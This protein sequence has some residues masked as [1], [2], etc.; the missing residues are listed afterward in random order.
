[1]TNDT[2]SLQSEQS[3]NKIDFDAKVNQAQIDKLIK[4]NKPR[5][6]KRY[7]TLI[8]ALILLP[9]LG[10]GGFR[11]YDYF[12]THES[13]DDAYVQAHSDPI[14]SRLSGTVW[15]VLVDDNQKVKA[16]DI[17]VKLDPKDYEVKV[18]QAQSKV[19]SA[20]W[21][22]KASMRN[23]PVSQTQAIGENTAA[24]GNYDKS[25]FAI[26]SALTMLA[27]DEIQIKANESRLVKAR[28]KVEK[29][30]ADYERYIPLQKR[31][32]ITDQLLDEAKDAYLEAKA[33]EETQIQAIS[34][35]KMHYQQ[36]RHNLEEARAESV[37]FHGQ[38]TKAKATDMQT[39][40]IKRQSQAYKAQ[41]EEA[42][43]NLAEA[44]LNLSYTD[45][46]A[47][48][49][50]I[51]GRKTVETGQRVQMGEALMAVVESPPWIVANFKEI[52]LE[53]MRPNQLVEITV[54][55]FKHHKFYGYIDSIAPNSGSQFA[56]LPPDNATGNFTKIVQRVP[57]K[58]RFTPD[59]IRG[60]EDKVVPGL[61]CVVTVDL[62]KNYSNSI[63]Q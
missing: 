38:L 41:Y 57:V 5:M 25:K 55:A 12:M 30:L 48:A 10:F 4:A 15:Q 62:K 29:T 3:S 50:G 19:E 36:S 1:M 59:S 8:I 51:I 11:L 24:T 61:S 32:V 52:Q 21:Q 39:E 54:D 9:I 16:G 43:A 60:Y 6:Q 45:I 56:L 49:D 17:L 26:D 13:T 23:L 44:K 53:K 34:Q 2:N 33:D 40:V 63:K 35:A 46:L 14:S 37:A 20:Y 27:Q 28:A 18:S 47:P 31:G 58:I 42:L 7:I 22:F